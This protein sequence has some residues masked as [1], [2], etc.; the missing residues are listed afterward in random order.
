MLARSHFFMGD[1]Y[2]VTPEEKGPIFEKGVT[3]GERAMGADPEFKARVDKGEKPADALSALQ[4]DDQMAI[5]WTAA[6]L[7]KWAR[8]QGFTTIVKYKSY[9]AKLMTRC[10][11]LDETAFW[12]G[13]VRYWGGFYSVA[14]AFA[15]GDMTKSKEYF[16]R[17]KTMF[18]ENLTTYVL[19][20]DTYATKAQDREL[21]KQLLDHVIAA[22]SGGIPELQPE[23]ENE[24]RKAKDLLARID[25]LFAD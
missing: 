11:E 22:D 12:G 5:Y 6:S 25:E 2:A 14:P 13:P 8:L 18:P 16:E 19:Y 23:F 3:W 7:G 10:T 21:F 15:G 17:A 20:A 1:A 4:K 9:I 24:K